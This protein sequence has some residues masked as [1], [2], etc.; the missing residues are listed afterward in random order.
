MKVL[1]L[2]CANSH[3]F[4]GW[5][6]SEQDFQ[7]QLARGLVQCPL[8]HSAEVVKCLSA[9]RLNLGHSAEA[10]AAAPAATAEDRIQRDSA[11]APASTPTLEQLQSAWMQVARK[12]VEQTKD[13][14]DAFAS[15]AR[16]MH[17]GE[18][19]AEGIRGQASREQMLEL[20]EEGIDVIALPIPKHL[21][22]DLH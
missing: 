3:R 6:G 10:V 14:G 20:K 15:Q 12:L 11:S 7:Q 22:G 2:Q 17:Y 16:Q 9:P 5:F 18:I 1:D 13:V 21:H 4:E 19:P 8:C